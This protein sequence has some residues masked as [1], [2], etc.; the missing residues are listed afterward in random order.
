MLSYRSYSDSSIDFQ[1][2]LKSLTRFKYPAEFG[3]DC[4]C[5]LCNE[6]I[7]WPV[8]VRMLHRD[9]EIEGEYRLHP[10]CFN[11][12]TDSDLGGIWVTLFYDDESKT[13]DSSGEEPIENRE[14]H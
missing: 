13:R 5:S 2:F 3:E 14:G 7:E 6:E 10:K 12:V 1:V 4:K 11:K 8:G 9:H